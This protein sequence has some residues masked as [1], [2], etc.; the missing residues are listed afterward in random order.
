MWP[1]IGHP[2]WKLSISATPRKLTA[3]QAAVRPFPLPTAQPCE[4]C[5]GFTTCMSHRA[6][7]EAVLC[8]HLSFSSFSFWWPVWLSSSQ[9]EHI[10]AFSC[11]SWNPPQRCKDIKLQQSD[12]DATTTMVNARSMTKREC[13]ERPA[14]SFQGGDQGKQSHTQ[15]WQEIQ[16][17]MGV[18]TGGSH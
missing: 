11:V 17:R 3:T 5:V 14:S 13:K 12:H 9:E 8:A 15:T 16:S 6:G 1:L 18:H 2:S 10:L 7:R 4:C